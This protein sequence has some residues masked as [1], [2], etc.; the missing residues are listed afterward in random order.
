[1]KRKNS[2]NNQERAAL[3]NRIVER[4]RLVQKRRPKYGDA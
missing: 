2:K 3:M 4:V 1:M